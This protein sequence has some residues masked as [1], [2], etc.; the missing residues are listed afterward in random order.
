M[1]FFFL[2]TIS[3]QCKTQYVVISTSIKFFNYRHASNAFLFAD[4]LKRNGIR[5]NDIFIGVADDPSYNVRNIYPGKIFY[6]NEY[7]RNVYHLPNITGDLVSVKNFRSLLSRGFIEKTISPIKKDTN[8]T[9]VLYMTG[10][11]GFEFL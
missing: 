10:H 7:S 3:S 8:G 5:S 9:L 1:L 6:D 4:V 11:G 2:Y